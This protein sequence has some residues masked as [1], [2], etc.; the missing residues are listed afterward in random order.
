[1]PMNRDTRITLI[2]IGL[3]LGIFLFYWIGGMMLDN[4]YA[5]NQDDILLS[6][7]I[8][9]FSSIFFL[10]IMGIA[11][12]IAFTVKVLLNMY[13]LEDKLFIVANIVLIVIPWVVMMYN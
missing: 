3:L 7:I 1:M 13:R 8:S 10:V 2:N 9:G 6:R 4:S 5:K 11:L 12:Q